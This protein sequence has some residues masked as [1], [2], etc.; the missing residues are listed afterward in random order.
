MRFSFPRFLFFSLFFLFFF[1]PF[2]FPLFTAEIPALK[3]DLGDAHKV[4]SQHVSR[5]WSE[6][7]EQRRKKKRKKEKNKTKK[8]K[9]KRKKTQ[10]QRHSPGHCAI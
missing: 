10:L 4:L 8:E 7:L 9:T 5:I 3:L 2:F 6:R 1:F